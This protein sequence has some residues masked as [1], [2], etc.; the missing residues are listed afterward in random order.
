MRRSERRFRRRPA[1]L[2]NAAQTLAAEGL[3][4]GRLAAEGLA[5]ER[6]RD[7]AEAAQS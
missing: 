1:N 6:L 2:A 5:T 3:V 7:T 4:T